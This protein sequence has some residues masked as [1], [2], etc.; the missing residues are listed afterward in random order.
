M[1]T[2]LNLLGFNLYSSKIINTLLS[3]DILGVKEI[4]AKTQIPKNK[5]YEALESLISR[6]ILGLEDGKPKKY[7]IL[8]DGI[9]DEMLKKKEGEITNLKVKLEELK[10]SRDKINPSVLSIIDG[11][12]E[13]HRLIEYSNMSVKHEILS[14]SRLEKMYWGCFRTLKDAIDR[15]V[16]AKFIALKTKNNYEIL[17]NYYDIGVELRIYEIKDKV[18]PKIGLFDKKYTRITIWNPDVK[19]AKDFKTIWANSSIMYE[20]VK[21][22][23][24]TIWDDS[25]PFVPTV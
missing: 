8:N 24:D 13:V 16:K 4:Y 12:D 6:G 14:C 7:F 2:Q 23:F 1:D 10:K 19:T 18:F 15:G 17:K 25:T 20:I 5:I 22:H 3:G 21:N 9:F 11:D